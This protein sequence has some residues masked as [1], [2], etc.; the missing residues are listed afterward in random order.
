MR[1]PEQQDQKNTRNAIFTAWNDFFAEVNV[2]K[3]IRFPLR[4]L[5][6]KSANPLF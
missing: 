2:Y 1:E 5:M 4:M 3:K 6:P